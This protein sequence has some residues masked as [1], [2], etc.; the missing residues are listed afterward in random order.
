VPRS[1]GGTLCLG[2]VC[3]P[4]EEVSD[5]G[6]ALPDG[7]TTPDA[8]PLCRANG[9]GCAFSN[10][11]CSQVCTNGTCGAATVCQGLGG[12]CTASADCCSGSSCVIATGAEFGTCQA[13]TCV[14]SG[15]TCSAGGTPCCAGLGCL[16]SQL[17]PCGATGACTCTVAIN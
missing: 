16:T 15:Q 10:D 7:G 5:G 2:G 4:L 14:S 13:A 3:R 6:L 1:C 17:L 11:C 8:G 9:Q 12:I